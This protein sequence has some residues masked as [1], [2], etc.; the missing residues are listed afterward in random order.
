MSRVRARFLWPKYWPTWA[1]L[2]LL[3][4]VARWS[5]ARQ[6]AFGAALGALARRLPLPQ[7]RVVRRNL[8]LC[9][10]EK[11]AAER[12]AILRTHFED[13]GITLPETALVWFASGE[14]LRALVQ[15]EG[16]E[17]LDRVTASGRGA[18]LLAAHFTTLE[19]GAR[20]ATA[21]RAVHAVYKPSKNALLSEFFVRYRSAISAGTIA[22]DDIKRMVRV[23][24]AGGVVWYAP[25]QA[26][27]G[28]GAVLAPFFGIDAASN[29]AT[30]R[31][32]ALTGAA[33]LPY[34]VE[35]LPGTAGYRAR[36]GAPLENFPSGD[37]LADLRRFHA[38]IEREARRNPG[39]YLWLHKRFKGLDSRY[40]EVY[41]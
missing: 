13:A 32:A 29:P 7:R 17:E 14:R 10:P 34:F 11:T 20:F 37:P 28:K 41:R 15:F 38:L 35:R 1:A 27:R 25:D 4:V 21:T 23:L 31:L 36:I 19:I 5:F 18:I 39:Q 30:S 22:S 3:K 9:F 6:L 26:Y 16:L 40:P 12:E 8:E 24:R 33:V 2:W